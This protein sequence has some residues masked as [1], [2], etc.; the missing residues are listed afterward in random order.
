[1]KTFFIE[2]LGCAKNEVDSNNI[3][4]QLISKGYEETDNPEVADLLITNT[5]GFIQS[6]KE[7]SIETIL[8]LAE[9][10]K[11]NANKKLIVTGCFSQRNSK[12]LAVAIPEVDSFFGVDSAKTMVANIQKDGSFIEP[13]ASKYK[14]AIG[15]SLLE[16][17]KSSAYLKI[18]EG[19][20]NR[21]TYCAIPIIRGDFRSRPASDIIKEAQELGAKGIIEINLISQDCSNYQDPTNTNFKLGELLTELEKINS[22][23]WIRVLYLHP[24]HITTE[25]IEKIACGNKVIPY[26]DIPVQHLSNNILKAMNRGINFDKIVD[27]IRRIREVNPATTIRTTI[28]SGFP[29]ETKE[30]FDFLYENLK[31]IKF[32]ILGCFVYSIEEGTVAAQFNEQVPEEI[33][34]A[35]FEKIMALQ[36]TISEKKLQK[37]INKIIPVLIEEEVQEEDGLYLGRSKAFAPDVDGNV[38]VKATNKIRIGTVVKVTIIKSM[39]Y[40]LYGE[41]S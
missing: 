38:V 3:R 6:A 29:G 10:K 5:C 2:T 7:E 21:C 8:A 41:V 15:Y 34:Q 28:I 11:N 4:H 23:E 20:S 33:V 19:C 32:D 25:I 1:M 31:K 9:L 26:F 12:E 18:A 39:Q 17:S 35:R 27:L 24:A 37:Q 36:A 14:P 30:D 40:D 16:N 22:I 13:I